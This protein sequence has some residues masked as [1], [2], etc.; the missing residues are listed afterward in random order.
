MSLNWMCRKDVLSTTRTGGAEPAS[1]AAMTCNRNE[2]AADLATSSLHVGRGGG[3]REA[4][5][6]GCDQCGRAG[7]SIRA[8][9]RTGTGGG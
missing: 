9:V 3:T 8:Q 5:R 4:A 7:A 1:F 6:Q 2:S